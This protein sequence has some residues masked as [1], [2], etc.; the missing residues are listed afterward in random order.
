MGKRKGNWP[1]KTKMPEIHEKRQGRKPE[2]E[3]NINGV[4][5]KIAARGNMGFAA[6]P[7]TLARQP[8]DLAEVTISERG[9]FSS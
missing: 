2:C 3:S 4:I 5:G 6:I 8:R 1:M 7:E 9:K